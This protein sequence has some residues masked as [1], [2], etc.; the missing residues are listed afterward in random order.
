MLCF[1]LAGLSFFSFL[2]VG[3]VL[4]P[5]MQ[6]WWVEELLLGFSGVCAFVGFLCQDDD[7]EATPEGKPK[8][9]ARRMP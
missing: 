3:Y 2:V 9:K 1:I 8:P 6:F 7:P 5:R 4:Y